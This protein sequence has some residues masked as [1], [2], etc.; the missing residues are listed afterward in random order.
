MNFQ[1]RGV[2]I[3]V[4]G[5]RT[6]A[7]TKTLVSQKKCSYIIIKGAKKALLAFISQSIQTR[8]SS[9]EGKGVTC[10]LF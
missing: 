1:H 5:A 9:F 3:I 2:L 8:G 6:F 4:A 10:R 7:Q